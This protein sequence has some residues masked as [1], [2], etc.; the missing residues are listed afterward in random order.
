[1]NEHRIPQSRPSDIDVFVATPKTPR[2]VTPVEMI[3]IYTNLLHNHPGL[4]PGIRDR[5]QQ[6]LAYWRR[7]EAADAEVQREGWAAVKQ[8]LGMDDGVRR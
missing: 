7:I 2:L 1:M 6:R 5:W 3:D 4:Y 8:S